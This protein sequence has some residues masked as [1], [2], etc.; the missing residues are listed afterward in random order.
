MVGCKRP[1]LGDAS[2]ISA[3]VDS[4]RSQTRSD[5]EPEGEGRVLPGEPLHR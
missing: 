2:T 3:E 5:L 1:M 4:P